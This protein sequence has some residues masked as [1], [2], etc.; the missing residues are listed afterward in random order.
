MILGH[1]GRYSAGEDVEI[2]G[3]RYLVL[4]D[5]LNLFFIPSQKCIKKI[6]LDSG[7]VKHVYDIKTTY[8]RVPE[9]PAIIE[10]VKDVLRAKYETLNPKSLKDSLDAI[11]GK[12]LKAGY[13]M[14]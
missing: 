8:E 3:G 6:R 12:L 9:H 11:V 10:N 14:S 2:L 7:K 5:Y 4:E 13:R 1:W